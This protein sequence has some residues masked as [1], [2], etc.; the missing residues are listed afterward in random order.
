[1]KMRIA[2]SPGRSGQALTHASRTAV[3]CLVL[4]MAFLASSPK[5]A[6]HRMGAASIAVITALA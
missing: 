6:L 1:M 2:P 4:C 3:I 5:A